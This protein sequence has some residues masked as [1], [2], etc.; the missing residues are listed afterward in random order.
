MFIPKLGELKIQD[1]EMSGRLR[2]IIMLFFELTNVVRNHYDQRYWQFPKLEVSFNS[3]GYYYFLLQHKNVSFKTTCERAYF[4]HTFLLL[5][6]PFRNSMNLNVGR[7]GNC[8]RLYICWNGA[9]GSTIRCMLKKGVAHQCCLICFRVK[10]CYLKAAGF[11][12][13][14]ITKQP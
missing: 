6:E 4:R 12:H 13:G 14:F 2:Q 3:C 1:R 10:R 8:Y 5:S 11:C 7:G 9:V